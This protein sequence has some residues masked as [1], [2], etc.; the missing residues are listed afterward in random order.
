VLLLQSRSTAM[1]RLRPRSLPAAERQ[2]HRSRKVAELGAVS[3]RGREKLL[4]T[5]FDGAEFASWTLFVPLILQQLW[6]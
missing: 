4:V 5:P 6:N 3:S 1:T 2:A